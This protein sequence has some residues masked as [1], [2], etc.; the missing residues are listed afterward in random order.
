MGSSYSKF[1]A[2]LQSSTGISILYHF[3][4]SKVDTCDTNLN[5]AL[6]YKIDFSANLQVYTFQYKD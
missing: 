2:C 6:V 4:I 3:I 5:Y 1:D